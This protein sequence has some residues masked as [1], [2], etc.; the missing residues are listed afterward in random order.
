MPDCANCFEIGDIICNDSSSASFIF[1]TSIILLRTP[2]QDY[3]SLTFEIFAADI[4]WT[5]RIKGRLLHRLSL[6]VL[7]GHTCSTVTQIPNH[8]L[9]AFHRGQTFPSDRLLISTEP[10][11]S[12]KSELTDS[13]WKGLR[14]LSERDDKGS[15]SHVPAS[16]L[17]IKGGVCEVKQSSDGTYSRFV[18]QFSPHLLPW[19]FNKKLW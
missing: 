16:R 19:D 15:L 18:S 7:M 12:F 9:F 4:M 1:S 17:R 5:T 8:S 11:K 13:A 10:F 6:C 2:H 14:Q 3:A